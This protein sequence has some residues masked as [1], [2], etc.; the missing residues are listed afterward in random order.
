MRDGGTANEQY[1]V[2]DTQSQPGKNPQVRRVEGY[3][4]P[5]ARST[6]QRRLVGCPGPVPQGGHGRRQGHIALLAVAG[7]SLGLGPPLHGEVHV[8]HRVGQGPGL[9][10]GLDSDTPLVEDVEEVLQ[11]RALVA[12]ER[13]LRDPQGPGQSLQCLDGRSHMAVL[14]AG[15]SGFGDPRDFLKVRLGVSGPHPRLA[16]TLTKRP[17]IVHRDSPLD[18]PPPPGVEGQYQPRGGETIT[19]AGWISA[20][21]QRPPPFPPRPWRPPHPAGPWPCLPSPCCPARG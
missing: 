14:I 6:R 21:P 20:K 1:T 15:Q 12:E 13:R 10:R 3:S 18:P 19:Q 8:C 5:E 2:A 9:V 17:L 7:E 16:Q 11:D 4:S